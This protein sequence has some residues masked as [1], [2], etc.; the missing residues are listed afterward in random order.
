[1]EILQQGKQENRQFSNNFS[2]F[3]RELV[4][5]LWLFQII[6]FCHLF[7]ILSFPFAFYNAQANCRVCPQLQVLE[8]IHSLSF[9][10]S[11]FSEGCDEKIIN[12][13]ADAMRNTRMSDPPFTF[14]KL[15]FL[16]SHFYIVS[17]LYPSWCWCWQVHQQNRLHLRWFS[18]CRRGGCL[19]RLQG[20]QGTH[21]YEKAPRWAS[22]YGSLRCLPLH[23]CPSITPPSR[24]LLSFRVWLWMIALRSPRSSPRRLRRSLAFLCM[25]LRSPSTSRYLYEYASNVSYRKTLPQIRAGEYEHLAEKIVQPE[26]KPDFGPAGM[27]LVSPLHSL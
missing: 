25:S 19:Q 27:F 10:F 6:F 26:W 23:P 12:A 22:S 7:A 2:V 14:S 16:H 24:W 13:I 21:W 5:F 9:H 11:L 8:S 20:R 15:F 1:M 3:F 17:W 4:L 18:R